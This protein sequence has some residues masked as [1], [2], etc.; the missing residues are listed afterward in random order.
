MA[1]PPS[2]SPS[3]RERIAAITLFVVVSILWTVWWAFD[4]TY[5]EDHAI[6]WAAS[7]SDVG[8][9]LAAVPSALTVVLTGY[10][11]GDL[12][13]VVWL[14]WFPGALMMAVGFL[15]SA[16]ATDNIGW[17]IFV[18]GL[19]LAFGWPL[20]FLPLIGIGVLLRGRRRKRL[21]AAASPV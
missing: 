21:A 15:A 3:R 9:L 4:L 7:P 13:A 1:P 5:G 20:Y 18:G 16:S 8:G 17:L 11:F 12:V 10:L 6:H 14:G 19:L 2:I